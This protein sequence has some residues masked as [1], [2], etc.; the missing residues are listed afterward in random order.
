MSFLPGPGPIPVLAAALALGAV[1]LAAPAPADAADPQLAHSVVFALKD[2]SP[3]ARDKFVASCEKYLTGHRGTVTFAVGVIADD[4]VEPVSDRDFD[5]T[6]HV[7]FEDKG[8]LDAYLKSERHGQFVAENKD[9]F[10]KVRVFD[11]YLPVAKPK[12]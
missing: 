7:V 2:K 3:A 5:V 9:K 6:V 1:L 8:M 4:V 12:G 10:A 11:S